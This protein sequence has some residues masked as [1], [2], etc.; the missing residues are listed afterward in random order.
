MTGMVNLLEETRIV[1][2]P[3]PENEEKNIQTAIDQVRDY[4]SNSSVYIYP[5]SYATPDYLKGVDF[6][7]VIGSDYFPVQIVSQLE[8]VRNSEA[9]G[10]KVV[11]IKKDFFPDE[12][13]ERIIKKINYLINN[14]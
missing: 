1:R 3:R 13:V 6:Y 14:L 11:F 2:F 7:T 5:V 12:L 9:R 8:Q 4:F 10:I